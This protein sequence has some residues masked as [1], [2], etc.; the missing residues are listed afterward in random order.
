[1][2]KVRASL[3]VKGEVP[4]FPHPDVTSSLNTFSWLLQVPPSGTSPLWLFNPHPDILLGLAGAESLV[5][6]LA[7]LNIDPSECH[8]RQWYS[9][10]VTCVFTWSI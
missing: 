5:L 6:L 1:M 7:D 3:N 2:L 8:R 4:P 10:Q 9:C